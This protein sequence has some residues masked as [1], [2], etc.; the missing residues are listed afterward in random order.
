MNFSPQH[1]QSPPEAEGA[2]SSDDTGTSATYQNLTTDGNPAPGLSR[3]VVPY[4][5]DYVNIRPSQSMWY[6]RLQ[7]IRPIAI[8]W[9][10]NAWGNVDEFGRHVYDFMQRHV[11]HILVPYDKLANLAQGDSAGS[12]RETGNET[13]DKLER[14]STVVLPAGSGNVPTTEQA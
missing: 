6:D 11:R 8:E 13:Y 2:S 12:E 9:L 14:P 5:R 1:F 10:R 3:G 7:L 4:G